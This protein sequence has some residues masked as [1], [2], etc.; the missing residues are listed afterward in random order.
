MLKMSIPKL[1]IRNQEAGIE[2]NNRYR[3]SKKK[4]N[5]MIRDNC[6]QLKHFL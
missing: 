4:V 2:A 5:Q 6:I 3:S 1:V